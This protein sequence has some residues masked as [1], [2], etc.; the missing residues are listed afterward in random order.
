MIEFYC[1]NICSWSN[2]FDM[3]MNTICISR[4]SYAHGHIFA[5]C[6]YV[7]FALSSPEY[8]LIQP[9][10][11]LCQTSEFSGFNTHYREHC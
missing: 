5:R 6:L 8:L 11:S 1:L 4:C 7:E 10:T 9:S 3:I 2:R